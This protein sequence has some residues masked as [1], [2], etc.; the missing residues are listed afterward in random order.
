MAIR[1]YGLSGSGMDVD[2]LVKDMMSA[3][4]EQYD[5]VWQKKTQLEWKKADY[6]TMYTTVQAFRDTTAFNYRLSSTTTPKIV[7]SSAEGIVTATANADAANVSRSI[8][9]DQLAEGA[10]VTSAAEISQGAK[11]SLMSQFGLAEGTFEVVISDGSTSKTIQVDTSKSIYDFVSD[12]NKS[13]LKIRA[14]YDASLDRFNIS[15]TGTGAGVA[16]DFSE[17][18]DDEGSAGISGKEFITDK[19]K[20]Y[21]DNPDLKVEGKNAKVQLDGM[22]IEQANNSFTAFGVTY[23]L[24]AEGTAK[25]HVSADNDKAVSVVKDF[26]EKYNSLLETINSELNEAK[27]KSY[28]P[29]TNEMKA[30]LSDSQITQW[31]SMARS[32]L[33]RNDS[34]LQSLIY[35]LRNDV[36]T[37]VSG[38]EGKYTSLSAIGVT[39]GDYTE[40]GKLH[41]NETKLREALE[42]DPDIVNKLFSSSGEDRNTQ[43]VAVRFYDTLKLT[44]DSIK[45]TAGIT[46]TIDSD[47]QSTLAKQ[48]RNY[49]DDLD[50]MNDRLIQMEE[51]YYK[52]FNA[53]EVALSKLSQQSSWLANM[54]SSGN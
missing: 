16:I 30:E 33:M 40:G 11:G 20:L 13:G 6:N 24:K 3:R 44:M 5:K 31:E 28:M 4:R 9:V 15:T 14:S 45:E 39:T 34:T 26:I 17:T 54:F 41:L 2:Q 10:K 12:L 23:N 51:R 53:M 25:I 43:G 18:T 50:R 47:T 37:P 1:T 52:Q 46:A 36:A 42:A 38:V 49:E 19:L 21:A 27:Y 35:K 32:G 22:E 48:I 29:L 8:T 7:T